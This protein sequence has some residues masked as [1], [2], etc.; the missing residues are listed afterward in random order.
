MRQAHR[1]R[2]VASYSEIQ[3]NLLNVKQAMGPF[4]Y[5]HV[6]INRQKILFFQQSFF[7]APNVGS[8]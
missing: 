5:S 2:A 3:A 1:T 4:A 6:G 8:C 7:P